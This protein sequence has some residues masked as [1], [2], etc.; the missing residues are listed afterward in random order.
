MNINLP[1]VSQALCKKLLL[2]S[3]LFLFCFIHP[4]YADS[5]KAMGEGLFMFYL[6]LVILPYNLISIVLLFILDFKK[7]SGIGVLL[8]NLVGLP[9]CSYYLYLISKIITDG[10]NSEN[11]THRS[12][13]HLHLFLFMCAFAGL[14]INLISIY[15]CM[16]KPKSTIASNIK[17]QNHG[18][19]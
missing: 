7:N 15:K 9:F 19:E 11:Y 8:F 2:L 4:V 10:L 14:V 12:Y 3:S 1:F 13:F 16:S 18:N 17:S 6:T 5:W